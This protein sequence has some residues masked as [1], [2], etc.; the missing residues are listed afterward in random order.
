MTYMSANLSQSDL[1]ATLGI[2]KS[3]SADLVEITWPSGQ[4]QIFRNI[5]ADKFYL[6]QE[7]QEE[8][9]LQKFGP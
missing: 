3:T 7:G 9:R 2:G 1:R 6:V 4:R 5:N 8:V